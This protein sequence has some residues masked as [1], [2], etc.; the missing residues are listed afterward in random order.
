[1]LAGIAIA[2]TKAVVRIT[3][4]HQLGA[5]CIPIIRSILE[6]SVRYDCL[7]RQG[8]RVR[9][10]KDFGQ[11]E[12]PASVQWQILWEPSLMPATPASPPLTGGVAVAGVR[13]DPVAMAGE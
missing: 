8:L 13:N 2:A 1:M 9:L 7:P 10:N 6:V 4:L 5:R 3:I 11:Q 12:L